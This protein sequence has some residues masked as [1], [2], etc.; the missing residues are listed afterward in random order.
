MLSNSN[1][2]S[3]LD[4]VDSPKRGSCNKVF[5]WETTGIGSSPTDK[6]SVAEAAKRLPSGL[7]FVGSMPGTNSIVLSPPIR[8][9]A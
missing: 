6:S 5:A 2:R 4:Y 3:S 9:L 1:L 7:R 8:V